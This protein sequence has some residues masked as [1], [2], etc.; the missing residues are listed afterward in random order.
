MDIS[1]IGEERKME[2]HIFYIGGYRIIDI[3]RTQRR[4]AGDQV[5]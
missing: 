5:T 4:C 3:Y 1:R 2:K